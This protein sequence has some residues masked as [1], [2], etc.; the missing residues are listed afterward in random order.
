MRRHVNGDPGLHYRPE[1]AGA[2]R[3]VDRAIDRDGRSA[4]RQAR[5][6]HAQRGWDN[7][8]SVRLLQIER[9]AGVIIGAWPH[10]NGVGATGQLG[11]HYSHRR[12]DDRVGAAGRRLKI[13]AVIIIVAG[14]S[15]RDL[16]VSDRQS[17]D[18]QARTKACPVKG[19]TPLGFDAQAAPFAYA[20][21]LGVA[22]LGLWCGS[23]MVVGP[24]AAPFGP[25]CRR[26]GASRR[27][28]DQEYKPI[29]S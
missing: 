3:I 5:Y 4:G 19:M 27:Q 7:G 6:G 24:E 28:C 20:L 26:E 11:D 22:A 8:K 14:A 12:G 16:D 2:R 10:D 21:L 25:E 9:S 23:P 17:A 13:D 1:I 15:N 18:G 29:I